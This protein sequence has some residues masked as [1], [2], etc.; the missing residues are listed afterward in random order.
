[1]QPTNITARTLFSPP[2]NAGSIANKKM[3]FLFALDLFGLKSEPKPLIFKE[4]YK[5][6]T[7]IEILLNCLLKIR[8]RQ[9]PDETEAYRYASAILE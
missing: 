4:K 9:Q 3:A 1:M 8:K 5:E 7:V 2:Q 6:F